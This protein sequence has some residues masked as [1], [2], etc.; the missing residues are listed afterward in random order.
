MTYLPTALL[1]NPLVPAIPKS[2]WS[3]VSAIDNF[4]AT[5]KKGDL[6]WLK[7]SVLSVRDFGDV[8]LQRLDYVHGEWK[9]FLPVRLSKP[10]RNGSFIEREDF[11][12]YMMWV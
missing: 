1:D 10:Y 9:S 8:Y 6:M 12:F 7:S 4:I 5:G 2:E 3:V 11:E